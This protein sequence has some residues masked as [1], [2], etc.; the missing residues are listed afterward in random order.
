MKIT[1][2]SIEARIIDISDMETSDF[3]IPYWIVEYE[4]MHSISDLNVN[5]LNGRLTWHDDPNPQKILSYL[6]ELL[7][8]NIKMLG[9]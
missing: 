5:I 6:K 9:T 7:I 1:I 8:T 4:V 3:T 2:K